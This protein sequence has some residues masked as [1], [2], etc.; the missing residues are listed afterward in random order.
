EI[1]RRHE[2]LRTT[3]ALIEGEPVQVVHEARPVSLTVADLRHLPEAERE[4]EAV[5]LVKEEAALPF[6]LSA[7][8]LVRAS[9]VRL[10]EQE[11]VCLLTM[12]HIVSDGWSM[13][14]LIKEVAAL[15]AAYAK[16]EESPLPE[17]T[18]QYAD[19]AVWQRNWLRG[20][21]LDNQLTYWKRQLAGAPA[22]LELP[23]DRPRPRQTSFRGGKYFVVFPES[24]SARLKELSN[25]EGVTLYMTLLAAFQTLLRYYTRRDD[26]VVGT[27]VANRNR[28]ETEDLIGFFVNQL[29]LRTDLSGNPAFRELLGRVRETTLGAYAH[30]DLPFD[31]LVE[32]LGYERGSNHAPLFQVKLALQ[33]AP[34]GELEMS[35]LAL[36]E[37]EFERGSAAKLD[38]TLLLSDGA[39][40]LGAH[41]DY[42]ADLF[43]RATVGRFARLFESLLDAAASEPGASLDALA[44][45]LAEAERLERAKEARRR[46]ESKFMKLK[47]V[48]PKRV[49]A[50][51]ESLVK[52]GSLREGE[53]LPLVVEPRA[54]DLDLVAWAGLNREFV[55]AEL[56]RRGAL[57]FRGFKLDEAVDFERFAAATGERLFKDNGEHPRTSVSGNVYTPTF[58]PPEEKVLWH[59][60]NSFNHRWPSKIWFCCVV[61]AQ[62]GGETPVVDSR[63]VLSLIDPEVRERFARKGVMYVRN[64]GHGLGLSWQEVFR[65][66]ERAEVERRC[67]E[68]LTEFEWT[69]DGLLTTRAVRPAVVNHPRTGE[70][71]WFNQ[72]QHW[73]P[74]CLNP[75]TRASVEALFSDERLP[76]NCYY[77]DGS[78]IEDAVMEHVLGVYRQLEVSFPWQRGDIMLLDNLLAAHARNP[79]KGPRRLLVAMGDM[80]SY[81]D[82]RA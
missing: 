36:G 34:E 11:H 39:N 77:G 1:V 9:L 7:G 67:R 30:Q 81:G 47:S 69:G 14:V 42:N 19:F 55:E 20:E 43:D 33:N 71:T 54:S 21:V 22:A 66:S 23:A 70:P 29:V 65:T 41:F 63:K 62:E 61:P 3:F 80:L 64:Y 40:G 31:H 12:H 37:F 75:A 16:G 45:S 18:V 17:L 38:L 57:L 73:H 49:G 10:S 48:K 56:S 26:I 60:E 6:D 15:Y 44:E 59:N 76:R 52:T 78:P 5:R 32:A 25:R 79:F 51:G 46:D 68:S 58:Y 13:G 50:A 8:P 27:D 24:L 35:G 2:V 53:S 28:A 74:S 4:A 82:V 72:A